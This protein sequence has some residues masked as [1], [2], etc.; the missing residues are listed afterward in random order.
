VVGPDVTFGETLRRVL[1]GLG[2]DARSA[3]DAATAT[4]EATTTRPHLMIVDY[5]LPGP[6]GPELVQTIRAHLGRRPLAALFVVDTNAVPTS[7]RERY[8]ALDDFIL[9]PTHTGAL[10]ERIQILLRRIRHSG[11]VI[12]ELGQVATAAGEETA[13]RR[14]KMTVMFTDVRSFTQMSEVRDPETVAA[15]LNALFADLA[16]AVLRYGGQID[17]F[18]G[19]GMMALFMSEH[20]TLSHPLAAV[21][22][23]ADIMR[24]THGTEVGSLLTGIDLRLGIGI[25]TGT[26]VIGP[27][28]PPFA[29]E[30]TAIGD[31]VNTA[32]RLCGEAGGH[33]IVI[34]QSTY[35]AVQDQVVVRARRDVFLKGKRSRQ[36]V[37]VIHLPE[38]PATQ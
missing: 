20:L 25:N 37:Y 12:R 24:S 36:S 15:A 34:S 28:G 17:K 29:R 21:S 32:A 3:H 31:T 2:Y 14:T 33:E 26:V 1:I 16:A 19:D 18:M 13:P 8:S 6:G 10:Q 35:D 7:L 23:A 38:A 5:D 11:A 30:I 4:V 9:K 22:A 27:I